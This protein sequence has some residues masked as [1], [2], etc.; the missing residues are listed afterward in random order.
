MP[1]QEKTAPSNPQSPTNNLYSPLK[2]IPTMLLLLTRLMAQ[3]VFPLLTRL[4]LAA[5]DR[6]GLVMT[7][8]SC[9][10]ERVKL[11]MRVEDLLAILTSRQMRRMEFPMAALQQSLA[12][13]KKAVEEKRSRTE[14]KG[15]RLR[16][17]MAGLMSLIPGLT[18][19]MEIRF[20]QGVPRH[21]RPALL[22]SCTMPVPLAGTPG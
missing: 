16:R 1:K 15:G 12:V 13:A 22:M 21:F 7:V 18:H 3:Q 10:G 14:R 8:R 6:K 11:G 5:E 4:L 20:W 17:R 9:L 19:C 2:P